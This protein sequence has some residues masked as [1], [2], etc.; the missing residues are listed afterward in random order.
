MRDVI[1]DVLYGHREHLGP[2]GLHTRAQF[3]RMQR[4]DRPVPQA[5]EV[6]IDHI[7]VLQQRED[8]AVDD[9]G[10]DDDRA[11]LVAL[12]RLDPLFVTLRRLELER[13]GRRLWQAGSF[14]HW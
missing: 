11:A 9:L 2:R 6:A 1:H 5:D 13:R 4:H 12:Q 14:P 8:I 10:A 3:D 7:V